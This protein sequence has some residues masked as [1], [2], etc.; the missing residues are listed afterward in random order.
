MDK[1]LKEGEELLRKQWLTQVLKAIDEKLPLKEKFN[2]IKV[3]C[4]EIKTKISQVNTWEDLIAQKKEQE[5]KVESD[6]SGDTASP[7]L[8][9]N[10]SI[11]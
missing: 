4:E 8:T 9:I 6:S 1:I 11:A 10:D 7:D 2:K 5:K 3:I